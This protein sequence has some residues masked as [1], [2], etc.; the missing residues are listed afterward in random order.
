MVRAARRRPG[1]PTCQVC[2]EEALVFWSMI[3]RMILWELLKI[4]FLA[5]IGL[6]GLILIAGIISE[7]MKNGFGPSQI[8]MIIPL[9]LPSLLPYTVPTTTLFATCIVYGRLSADNEILA[10]KAAGVHIKHIVWPAAFLGLVTSAVTMFCFIDI[11]PLTGCALRNNVIGDIEEL[12][13]TM[14]R[15]DGFIKHPNINV[16]IHVKSI[17]GR[18]LQDVIFKRKSADGNGFDVVAIAKEAELRV[19]LA[20]KLILVDMRHAQVMQGGS[21]GVIVSKIWEVE[22]PK[23]FLGNKNKIRGMDMTWSELFEYEEK[24][25]RQKEAHGVELEMIKTEIRLRGKEKPGEKER[26]ESL[27]VERRFQDQRISLIHAEWHWRPALS[28]GCLC[29]ALVGCPVGIWF[30]KS[31]YLSAFVTCFLPIVILYYPT[32]LCM[33]NLARD[34]KIPPMMA[35]YNGDL[36]MLVAGGVLFWRLARR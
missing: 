10:L 19:D 15:K 6:T 31:D 20:H 16:E 14:L 35:V 2:P 3:H 36:L 18:K 4:F 26:M 13:Y 7:A 1:L 21:G 27:V 33:Y 23:E 9:L 32:M 5:L 25:Q 12:L 29:F 17:Q 11:I 22:L 24:A 28:L 34:G 30:S 8:M